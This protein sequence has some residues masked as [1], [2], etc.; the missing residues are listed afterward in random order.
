MIIQFISINSL[1]TY[2][3]FRYDVWGKWGTTEL[4]TALCEWLCYLLSVLLGWLRT[5]K[6]S[7][8][9]YAG[10]QLLFLLLDYVE[11]ER[12]EYIFFLT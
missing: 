6:E 3:L 11:K 7:Q 2:A 5:L 8:G 4:V 9:T 12:D 10:M 1:I